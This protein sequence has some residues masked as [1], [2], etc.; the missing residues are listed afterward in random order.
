MR[1]SIASVSPRERHRSDYVVPIVFLLIGAFF[2]A[3]TVGQLSATALMFART[4]PLTGT[5]VGSGVRTGGNHGGMFYYPHFRY[6]A[7]D[8]MVRTVTSNAGSTEESYADGDTVSLRYRPGRPEDT[9]ICS[10]WTLWIGPLV[11]GVFG[12]AFGLPGLLI[13][14]A[15]RRRAP[16]D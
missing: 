12:S 6:R 10:F 8:G 13:L 3:L 15:L 14:L 7:P 11:C 4:V 16:A 1:R 5:Y 9:V 2:M